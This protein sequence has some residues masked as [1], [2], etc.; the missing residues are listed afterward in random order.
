MC[1]WITERYQ[2]KWEQNHL[3]CGVQSNRVL[4]AIDLCFLQNCRFT[5]EI[6]LYNPIN[7]DLNHRDLILQSNDFIYIFENPHGCSQTFV[8]PILLRLFIFLYVF[9][10]LKIYVSCSTKCATKMDV[11]YFEIRKY[12]KSMKEEEGEKKI[13]CHQINFRT[14]NLMN[15]VVVNRL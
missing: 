3:F 13:R 5:V 15:V 9:E 4:I 7:V 14:I 2:T 8:Q 12:F 1:A 11:I 10:Q 6:C